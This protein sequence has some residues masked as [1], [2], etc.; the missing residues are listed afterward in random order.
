[1][2]TRKN[3]N[4]RP[5]V[6]RPVCLGVGLQSGANDQNFV[7]CLTIAGLLMWGVLSGGRIDLYFT[8]TIASRSCQSSHCRVR[9]SQNSQPFLLSHMILP[10][11]GWPGSRIYIP[12]EEGYP[13]ISSGTGFP[14]RRL[15]QLA[16]LRLRYSNP[17]SHGKLSSTNKMK[18]NMYIQY[19]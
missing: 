12:Q 10:Q 13:V 1:M 6:S 7:F 14:F 19:I 18:S 2:Y 5:T 3:V 17:P 16:G 8:C 9:V 4:L 15:L 11:P